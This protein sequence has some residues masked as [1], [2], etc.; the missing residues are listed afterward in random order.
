MKWISSINFGASHKKLLSES[1]MRKFDDLKW[2]QVGHFEFF[3]VEICHGIS[4]P[5][6]AHFVL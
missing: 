2:P 1:L 5:G 4:L 6:T 3:Y